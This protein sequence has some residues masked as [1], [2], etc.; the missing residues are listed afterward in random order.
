MP[1]SG[2]PAGATR[3]API[4]RKRFRSDNVANSSSGRAAPDTTMQEQRPVYR[5]ATAGL[6]PRDVRLIEIVFKHS[7]YNR[8]EFV[9]DDGTDPHSIDVLLVNTTTP[10]GLQAVSAVR[11][12]ARQIPVVAAV[13][14]GVPSPARHAISIDRLTLQL[15]PILNKVV[16]SELLS[17][18]TQPMTVPLPHEGPRFQSAW[19]PPP[20]AGAAGAANAG[21]VSGVPGASGARGV[22][23]SSG[24]AKAHGRMNPEAP[25]RSGEPARAALPATN[26]SPPLA[27]KPASRPAPAA[28]GPARSVPT[29]AG[30]AAATRGPASAGPSAGSVRPSAPVPTADARTG[31]P[32]ARPAGRR[33]RI[34]VVDDSPT[35]RQQLGVAFTRMGFACELVARGEEALERLAAGRYDLV[36]ADV[37]IPDMDGF[38]LTRAIRKQH[39]SLPVIILSSRG[40]AF[41]YA[42]GLLAGCKA[43]LVK[44]V[45]LRE[46][47]AAILKVLKRSVPTAELEALLRNAAAARAVASR[48]AAARAAARRGPAPDAARPADARS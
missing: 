12:Q 36:M 19:Q 25:P 9:L 4:G 43:Y 23:G 7:Q 3:R 34:L 30:A 27:P 29:P 22:T 1:A 6:D 31:A 26:A 37:M 11:R 20:P 40:S 32:S 42:R 35:V 10:E 21:G 47:D 2:P 8:F 16:E 5:I 13:P 46:L 45:P 15:L 14:R 18:E 33:P 48:S 38:K 17:P 24:A 39:R 44:P 41:D 28:A